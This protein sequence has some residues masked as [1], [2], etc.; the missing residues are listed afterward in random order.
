MP[1]GCELYI[2]EVE[3]EDRTWQRRRAKSRASRRTERTNRAATNAQDGITTLT[4][5]IGGECKKEEN[6]PSVRPRFSGPTG[7][8]PVRLKFQN[9]YDKPMEPTKTGQIRAADDKM[10][11]SSEKP[12]ST[13]GFE[14][15]K[16]KN[17][18]FGS[19]GPK[20]DM[21]K[22]LLAEHWAASSRPHVEK[23]L[24][25]TRR[26]QRQTPEAKVEEQDENSAI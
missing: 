2:K 18:N 5:E 9:V 7:R 4:N 26:K 11:K 15:M 14:E 13:T 16:M 8:S 17:V 20:F 22:G 6:S 1:A 3:D 23:E 12:R 21:V 25:T 10:G 19:R 24:L